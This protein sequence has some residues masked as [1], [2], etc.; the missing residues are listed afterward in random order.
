MYIQGYASLFHEVDLGGDIIEPRAFMKCLAKR[1]PQQVKMLYQH[2]ITQPIGVWTQISERKKG[3]WVQGEISTQATLPHDVAIL[4][5]T[6]ALDGL[7]IGF[8]AIKAN[9]MKSG[10]RY[11]FE[12]DLVEIS[13]V[14][15][16]MQPKA[17]VSETQ[18]VEDEE[19][20][21]PTIRRATKKIAALSI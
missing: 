20:I 19:E 15:F 17:R 6:G 2:D 11:L 16:P 12:I 3:L 5:K 7:S 14:T 4:L 18:I 8:R 21:I 10:M 1:K 9:R 13:L